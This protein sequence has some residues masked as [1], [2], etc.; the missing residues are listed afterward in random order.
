MKANSRLTSTFNLRKIFVNFRF[1]VFACIHAQ[2]IPANL[3]LP[4]FAY[5]FSPVVEQAR[6]GTVVI[7]VDGCELLFG[8]AYQLAN[9]IASRAKKSRIHGGLESTVSIAIAANPDA[10]IHAATRLPGVTFVSPGE[11]LTCLGEFP[12]DH[13]DYSLVSIEKK[14]ADEILETLKLWGI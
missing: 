8:S 4:E 9:E 10:A 5:N 6:G 7:D 12:I 11:E 3:S 2:Q 1:I 13:L 14:V